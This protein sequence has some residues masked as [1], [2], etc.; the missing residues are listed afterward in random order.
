MPQFPID[1]PQHR[2]D[3]LNQLGNRLGP[4]CPYKFDEI[5]VVFTGY[6]GPSGE[7]AEIVTVLSVGTAIRVIANGETHI[8]T[9]KD[10]MMVSEVRRVNIRKREVVRG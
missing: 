10:P 9:V 6:R 3:L 4:T 7:M 5:E 2:L 1:D 8:G